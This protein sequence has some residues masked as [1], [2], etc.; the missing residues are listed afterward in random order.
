MKYICTN[1]NYIFDEI[2]DWN[3]D[4]IERVDDFTICPSC[5]EKNTFQGIEEVV[6]YPE[7][8]ENL[9]FLEIQ[10]YPKIDLIDEKKQI[11]KVS[12][13]NHPM[14]IEHKIISIWLYDEYWDLIREELILE[15]S[16]PEVEFDV[17]DFDE[18]EIRVKCSIHWVWGRKIIK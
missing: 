10:H 14:W 3:D 2:L 8:E 5:E 6:N 17:F 1:C 18:Y 15:E 11:I 16:I 9:E 12:F 7:N 13:E 4:S